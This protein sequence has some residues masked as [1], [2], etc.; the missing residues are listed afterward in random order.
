[1][2]YIKGGALRD[3]LLI[4]TCAFFLIC[5]NAL[6]VVDFEERHHANESEIEKYDENK[7]EIVRFRKSFLWNTTLLQ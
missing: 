6:A 3:I 5:P 4:L 1:M 2:V 7:N